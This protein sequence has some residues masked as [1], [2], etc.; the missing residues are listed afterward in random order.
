MDRQV[1]VVPQLGPLG[2]PVAA[3]DKSAEHN[4]RNSTAMETLKNLWLVSQVVLAAVAQEVKVQVDLVAQVGLVDCLENQEVSRAVQ[5]A[6]VPGRSD[7]M[8]R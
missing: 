4:Y 8:V 1:V 5:D 3:S 7:Q 6:K 2:Q